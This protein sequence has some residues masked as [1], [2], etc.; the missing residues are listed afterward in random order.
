MADLIR[1]VELSKY[2]EVGK[3]R[4]LHAVDHVSF[5]IPE[6]S[7]MGVVGESGC[8]KSTLGRVILGLLPATGG[9]MYYRDKNIIG[10]PKNEF[11]EVRHETAL[12]FQDPFSS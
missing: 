11:K 2:F 1:A 9:E 8:G 7:T 10:M 3:N 6:G 4:W 12:I 5:T